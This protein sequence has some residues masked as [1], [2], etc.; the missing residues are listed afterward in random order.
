MAVGVFHDDPNNHNKAPLQSMKTFPMPDHLRD[1]Q[2]QS[3]PDGY[4]SNPFQLCRFLSPILISRTRLALQRQMANS[5]L[6]QQQHLLGCHPLARAPC[7]NIRT[8]QL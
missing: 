4:H 7:H 1:Y 8:R 2:T 5:T 3:I 6:D